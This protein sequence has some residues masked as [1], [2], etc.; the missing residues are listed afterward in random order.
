[1]T[2][3]GANPLTFQQDGRIAQGRIAQGRIAQG[4]I[5]QGW[6]VDSGT[7]WRTENTADGISAA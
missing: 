4:W 6:K 1:L 2:E 3:Q 7:N 5:A